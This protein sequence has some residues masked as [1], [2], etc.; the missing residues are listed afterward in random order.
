ML[1]LGWDPGYAPPRWARRTSGSAWNSSE[2]PDRTTSPASHDVATVGE[3]H[4]GDVPVGH[5]EI[6]NLEQG[7]HGLAAAYILHSGGGTGANR[8]HLDHED[9]RVRPAGQFHELG[10]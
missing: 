4:R 5:R 9:V 10:V 3:T 2:V 7:T 1:A 8:S 6:L